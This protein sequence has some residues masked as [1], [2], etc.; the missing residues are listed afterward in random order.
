MCCYPWIHLSI[1]HVHFTL[2]LPV[3]QC[4]RRPNLAQ[5][6]RS[7]LKFSRGFIQLP[8]SFPSITKPCA[9]RSES[10]P[11]SIR[12]TTSTRHHQTEL[13]RVTSP[14]GTQ[15]DP[16]PSPTPST[17]TRPRCGVICR[18]STVYDTHEKTF[19]KIL[20]A[21]RGEI[22]CR[23]MKTCKKMGINTVAI[24]SDVDTNA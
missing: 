2:S 24:H 23:V 6:S 8:S 16:E 9:S 1:N 17:S 21:N 19:D 7:L 4:D 14:S 13:A 15:L 5:E 3:V 10:G 22:A 11:H 12:T 20:I 18:Y